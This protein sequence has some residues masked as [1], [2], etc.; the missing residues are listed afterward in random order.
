MI[1]QLTLVSI[2]EL[3]PLNLIDMSS[4]S[5]KASGKLLVYPSILFSIPTSTKACLGDFWYTSWR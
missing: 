5:T 2:I 1:C 3:L 4:F